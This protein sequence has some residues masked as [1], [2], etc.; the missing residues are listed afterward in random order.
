MK[1]FVTGATGFIGSAIV[2]ELVGTGHQVLGL[3]RSRCRRRTVSPPPGPRRIEVISEE[4]LE[5]CAAERI[6]A[7]GV[8]HTCF[9]H[10]YHRPL[11][12][13]VRIDKRAIETLGSALQGS[14]RLLLVTSGLGTVA[15]G[16]P[17]TEEDAPLP[18]SPSMP[19]ASEATAQTL[20]DRGVRVSVVR[21]PQVHNAVKQGFVTY[22]TRRSSRKRECPAYIGR[23]GLYP[24]GRRAR[25][26]DTRT[27]L[28]SR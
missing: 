23:D 21:L 12:K 9:I 4:I 1:I 13:T 11:Q 27:L 15:V 17:A 22:A 7:D 3:T 14:N 26:L 5:A 2:K 10:D 24:M 6:P 25:A 8:I 28:A 20:L 19:R 18:V 16:R